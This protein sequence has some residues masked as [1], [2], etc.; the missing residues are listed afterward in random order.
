MKRAARISSAIIILSAIIITPSAAVA[1]P[2]ESC[3]FIEVRAERETCYQRQDAARLERQRVNEV[4]QQSEQAKPY[5]PMT[6]D[7]AQLAKAMRGICRG[8]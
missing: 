7:D 1:A 8:C 3:R 2:P 6:A 5:E 4:R